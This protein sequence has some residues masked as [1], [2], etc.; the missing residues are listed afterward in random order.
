LDELKKFFSQSDWK[1]KLHEMGNN[2]RKAVEENYSRVKLAKDY[3]DVLNAV[4][5]N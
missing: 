5:S 1:E 4:R 3:I 2:G